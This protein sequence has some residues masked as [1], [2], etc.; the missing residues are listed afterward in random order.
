MLPDHSSNHQDCYHP[1]GWGWA[2]CTALI[3]PSA[4]VGQGTIVHPYSQICENVAIG[5]DCTLGQGTFVA[6]NVKIGRGVKLE[7]NIAV[8]EGV[9]IDDY[10]FLGPNVT[11]S[12]VK[13]P[14]AFL[15]ASTYAETHIKKGVTIGANAT[16][17]CGIT[18]GAYSL[19]GAGSVVTHDVLP[20][21]LVWGVPAEQK[22]WVCWCGETVA[23][24]IAPFI[25][26]EPH[27]VRCRPHFGVEPPA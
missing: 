19:I 2:H 4:R 27:Q 6:K 15:K 16:I 21:A 11:F 13:R 26:L 8:F 23:G 14:R 25:H 24:N 22:S 9:T 20:H 7:H 10:V 17:L 5:E 3:H 1:T 18:L 12:N